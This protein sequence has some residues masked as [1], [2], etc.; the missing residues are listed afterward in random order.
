MQKHIGILGFGVVGKSV[1]RF[2]RN[3][4]DLKIGIWDQRK[5]TEKEE[6]LI[7]EGS[8]SS[9]INFS[10][11]SVQEFIKLHDQVI[12]SPGINLQ[13]LLSEQ[14]LKNNSKKLI[15]ELDLFAKKFSKPSVAITGTLGKTSVTT[16][17][18]EILLSLN[19]KSIAGGNI[20][21]AMLNLIEHQQNFDLAVLEL[22]SFQLTQNTK[23]APKVAV[24]INFFPNHLDWHI[25]IQDYFNSK[26]KIF[27]YQNKDQFTLLS[28]DLLRYKGLK[29]KL[30]RVKS[31]ICFVTDS[32]DFALKNKLKNFSFFY[33]QGGWLCFDSKK[34]FD[35]KL[36]PSISFEQNWIF[37]LATLYLLNFDLNRL[38][39][40][41]RK[42]QEHRLELFATINGVDFYNDSK[43]TVIQATQQALHKLD[44]NG[45]PI[46]LILGG[47]SK[48]VDRKPLI[49]FLS[50]IKNLKKV[51]CF[52]PSCTDF[53]S[54]ETYA[55][56]EQ[57]L[58]AILQIVSSEDQVLFSPSG[59]SFDLFDNYRHRGRIF[60]ELVLKTF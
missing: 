26:C 51:I 33:R 57:T 49:K 41:K 45:K 25:D 18:S 59:A 3:D 16:L 58:N 50:Q 53:R 21:N 9:F 29:E 34:I 12:V 22:S 4:K 31:K 40:D 44:Q 27:E 37:V 7:K 13:K 15:G 56:L 52:G 6:K 1:L 11:F 2:L 30:K 48:G 17:L 39:L 54:F 43:A 47:L 55:S 42:L 35:L 20:G 36:L 14:F 19:S 46:I 23:F 24:W 8:C 28:S 10:S 60:K 38:V 32:L 5:L